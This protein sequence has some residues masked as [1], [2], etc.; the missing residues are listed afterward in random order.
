MG[1]MSPQP[2]PVRIIGAAL[3]GLTLAACATEA[4]PTTTQ[5]PT[6]TVT[7]MTQP[8][9]TTRPTMLPPTATSIVPGSLTAV[10][11]FTP[12]LLTQR[13][14]TPIYSPNQQYYLLFAADST[15]VYRAADQHLISQSTIVVD[16]NQSEV[17]WAPNS[18]LAATSDFQHA[19]LWFTDG[20]PPFAVPLD[21]TYHLTWASDSTRLAAVENAPTTDINT[22]VIIQADGEVQRI[23]DGDIR[24]GQM[25]NNLDWITRNVVQVWASDGACCGLFVYFNADTAQ[26]YPPWVTNVD[27]EQ[28]EA[29]FSP[30]RIWR[31]ARS[32]YR[33]WQGEAY[34]SPEYFEHVY[35]VLNFESGQYYKLYEGSNQDI[36]WVGWTPD[37]GTFYFINRPAGPTAAANADLPF[38]WLALSPATHALRMVFAQAVFAQLS[39]DQTQACVVFPAKDSAGRVGLD[40]AWYNMATGTLTERQPIANQVPYSSRGNRGLLPPGFAADKCRLN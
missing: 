21:V 37:S 12:L 33:L 39:A 1:I 8:S 25:V 10:P 34:A 15:R 18:Q 23:G 36:D 2:L 5:S 31:V 29:S 7:G 6:A 3:L 19:Y 24:P 11:S 16:P 22:L 35:T 14:A 4:T 9:P 40:A 28:L 32:S 30:D 20:R 26:F 13:A 17:V 27:G 38:G